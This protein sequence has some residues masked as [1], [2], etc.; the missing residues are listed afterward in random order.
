MLIQQPV[1][2]LFG[3]LVG[4]ALGF[5]AP[6][7]RAVGFGLSRR[8]PALKALSERLQIDDVPHAR[9]RQKKNREHAIP[10]KHAGYTKPVSTTAL[11]VM[12]SSIFI[13]GNPR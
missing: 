3:L 5:A 6:E 4:H 13:V 8:L 2:A 1:C 11:Q 10:G 7:S 12:A 9:P